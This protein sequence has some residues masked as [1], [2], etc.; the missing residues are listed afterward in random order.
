MLSIKKKRAAQCEPP[1]TRRTYG[2]KKGGSSSL[3]QGM[4]RPT[5]KDILKGAVPLS[6]GYI[7]HCNENFRIIFEVIKKAAHT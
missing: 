4:S 3:L 5:P 2:E 7:G 6:K 1:Y